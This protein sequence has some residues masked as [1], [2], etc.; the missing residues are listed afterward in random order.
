[1]RG[2]PKQ[3]RRRNER[4]LFIEPPVSQRVP[5]ANYFFFAA[6]LAPPRFLA[7][8]FAADFF[9]PPRLVADFFAA[10]FAPPRFAADFLAPPRFVAD[11]FAARFA[12][13][14]FA[15][16]FLAPRFAVFFAA[17]FL[18]PPRFFAGAFFAVFLPADFFRLAAFLGAGA[19]VAVGIID[20]IS[21][22]FVSPV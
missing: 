2:L 18:A 10:R 5:H 3:N 15:A 13:P 22:I 4:R 21:A 17:D 12:P 7:D 8:F 11:F 6:L 20:M 19:W 14:R 9:A 16:D 1:L